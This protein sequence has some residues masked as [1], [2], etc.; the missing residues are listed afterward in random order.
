M[1]QAEKMKALYAQWERE[2]EE[3]GIQKGMEKG[4][5]ELR[6]LFVD[7]YQDRF[8]SLPAPLLAA[9]EGTEDTSRLR[10]WIGLLPKATVEEI[11]A[12]VLGGE[13]SGEP[14]GEP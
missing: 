13:E 10:V 7:L 12:A 4:R 3:R 5:S 11:T 6:K 9:V 2:V 1:R 14:A 8:G